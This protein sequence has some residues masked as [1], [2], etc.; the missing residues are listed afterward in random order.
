MN[1]ENDI[2][3]PP[4][5]QRDMPGSVV[6]AMRRYATSA[7]TDERIELVKTLWSQGVSARRIARELGDDI[8]RSAVLGKVHRLGIVQTSPN[9]GAQRS[10]SKNARFAARRERDVA[11]ELPGS[12]RRLPAW[13]RNAEP[14]VDNPLVDAD[15]PAPQRRVLLELSGRAC[16]WP[17]GDPSHS[18]FFFCGAEAFQGKPYCVAHCAR[19]YRPEEATPPERT[20]TPSRPRA[21]WHWHFHQARRRRRRRPMARGGG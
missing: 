7:W 16:R 3:K 13:V 8:S 6:T 5:P 12:Q 20:S 14:Y 4:R 19:A 9:S 15:I 18:D 21:S 17:V 2:P 11:G 1:S 10:E